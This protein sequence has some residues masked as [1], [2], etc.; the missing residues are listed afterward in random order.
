MAILRALRYSAAAAAAGGALAS[1]WALVPEE[2]RRKRGLFGMLP[3]AHA[4]AMET[5][6]SSARHDGPLPPTIAHMRFNELMPQPTNPRFKLALVEHSGDED[7]GS[8]GH[9]ADSVPIANGIIKIGNSCDI[10]TYDVSHHD[11]FAASVQKYDA[12][13]VRIPPNQLNMHAPGTQERFDEL[14]DELTARGKLVWPDPEVQRGMGAK[15][16][17]YAIR[18]LACGMADTA[19]Y[20]TREEFDKGLK[21]TVAFQ[22]RVIKQNRGSGGTGVWA[23]W[24]QSKAY[25][26]NYGDSTLEDHDMLKLMEM[27]DNH[28]EY[29]TVGEF[30]EFCTSGTANPAKSGTQAAYGRAAHCGPGR[31][32]PSRR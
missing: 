26:T 18:G 11:D 30:V 9:R 15:E 4:V 23:V 17:L 10:L 7:K 32:A 16:A 27:N 12:L 20:R 8:D 13:I 1:A 29:H 21:A 22:P 6:F 24:C 3:V 31:R 5:F 28:V 25:C 19:V 2:E 14:M